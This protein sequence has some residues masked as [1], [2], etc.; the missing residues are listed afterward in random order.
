MILP[1]DLFIE[2]SDSD[3]Y[4]SIIAMSEL[5]ISN[6]E[7]IILL[8]SDRIHEGKVLFLD[9]S[10]GDYKNVYL[11]K[12][13]HTTDKYTELLFNTGVMLFNTNN[14]L[15]VIKEKH[16]KHYSLLVTSVKTN[17]L[18]DLYQRL[19]NRDIYKM[20]DELGLPCVVAKTKANIRDL[21]TVKAIHEIIKLYNEQTV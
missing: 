17:N 21:D 12:L 15:E 9:T 2:G 3:F 8:G 1:S 10:L 16:P 6:P 20:I 7:H 18:W 11:Y 14:M 5:L 13:S 19:P 4:R